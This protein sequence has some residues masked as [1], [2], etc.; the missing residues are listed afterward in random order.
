MV[1][2]S[3]T[4]LDGESAGSSGFVHGEKANLDGSP[5]LEFI[6]DSL[7]DFLAGLLRGSAMPDELDDHGAAHIFDYRLPPASGAGCSDI[8]VDIK[9]CPDDGRVADPAVKFHT[10]S[11]GGAGSGEVSVSVASQHANRVVVL[12]IDFRDAFVLFRF[13][14]PPGG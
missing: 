8:V 7:Y 3:E 9:T 6:G 13:A 2:V 4:I 11:A 1:G 12:N 5:V 14:F 10:D